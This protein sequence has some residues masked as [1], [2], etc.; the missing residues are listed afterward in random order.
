MSFEFL[1]AQRRQRLSLLLVGFLLAAFLGCSGQP[2]NCLVSG[3]VEWEGKPVYPGSVVFRDDAGESY[4]GNLTSEGK[5]STVVGPAGNY[6]VAIQVHQLSG[7]SRL[8]P[9]KT[10]QKEEDSEPPRREDKIPDQ[11]RNANIDIPAKYRQVETSELVF[12]IT[13][14]ESDLGKITLSK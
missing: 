11:F 5:F 9:P 7:L 13:E 12:E 1:F 14:K 8:P 4:I 6:R 2:S 3:S 10:S